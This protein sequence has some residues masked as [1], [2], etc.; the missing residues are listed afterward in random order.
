MLKLHGEVGPVGED[1]VFTQRDYRERLYSSAAYMTFLRSLF[2]TSTVL[3]LG[4]S[5]TDAYLNELRSEVLAMLDHRS[6]DLRSPTRCSTTSSPT[7]SATSPTTR[8]SGV[9]GYDTAGGTDWSGFEQ[10][11][12]GSTTPPTRGP[13][14]AGP[15]QGG[16]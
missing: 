9:I 4:V 15:S 13:C 10:L 1:V 8:A 6:E 11:L 12:R 2:A 7:S 14:W 3:F 5:F 16:G